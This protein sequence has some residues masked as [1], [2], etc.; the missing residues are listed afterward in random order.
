MN[1]REFI[2]NGLKLGGALLAGSGVITTLSGLLNSNKA[3]AA[4]Y[5]LYASDLPIVENYF[6][7]TSLSERRTTRQIIVHHSAM[8][9]WSKW[10]EQQKTTV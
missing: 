1:R 6:N 3:K 8:K 4:D 5:T 9:H 2:L 10:N 7:F